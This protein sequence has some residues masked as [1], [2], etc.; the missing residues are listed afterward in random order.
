M[1]V[2]LLD[3]NAQYAPILED[4]RAQFEKVFT[5]HHYIMGEQVKELEDKMQQYLGIKHAIGC[6]SGT[7]DVGKIGI[8]DSILR[9]RGK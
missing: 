5:T 2:Q 7:H 1:K 8:P 4:I 9:K 3:L 6:A